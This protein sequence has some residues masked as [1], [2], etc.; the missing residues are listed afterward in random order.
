[1]QLC[2]YVLVLWAPL[3][4]VS[5]LLNLQLTGVEF[6]ED[7]QAEIHLISKIVCINLKDFFALLA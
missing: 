7:S 6:N 5:F 1:M 4:N 3:H 2:Q